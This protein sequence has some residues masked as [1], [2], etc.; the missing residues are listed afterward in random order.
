MPA[1]RNENCVEWKVNQASVLMVR[2]AAG[3]GEVM[4]EIQADSIFE[5]IFEPVTRLAVVHRIRV[6]PP[7][8]EG[9]PKI[10]VGVIVEETGQLEIDYAHGFGEIR[11]SQG[12]GI[13]R[14][15]FDNRMEVYGYLVEWELAEWRQIGPED[16]EIFATK[17]LD[18]EW[19][20]D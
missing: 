8:K 18:P 11:G 3:E 19:G 1:L 16:S 12:T 7:R 17:K 15:H 13:T 5:P 6:A 9:S 4:M 10:A 2:K 20:I 14:E